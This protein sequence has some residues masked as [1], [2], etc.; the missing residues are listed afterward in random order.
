MKKIL[1]CDDEDLTRQGIRRILEKN[2]PEMQ[3]EECGNGL[4][5][6]KKLSMGGWDMLISDIKM[7][8]MSGLELIE[9]AQNGGFL[10]PTV[11]ISAYGEF[12]YAR[13][14]VRFGVKEYL[15]KPINRFELVDCVKRIL[16]EE[17][18][19]SASEP[20]AGERT[21]LGTVDKAIEYI[22]KNFFKNISLEEVSKVVF[23]NPNYFSVLFKKE[24]GMKYI[25]YL[26]KLRLEKADNLLSSTMLQVNEV[27]T[28][29]GY[30][31]TKYF[32]RLYKDRYGIL[33]SER[34]G[35]TPGEKTKNKS[36]I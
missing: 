16:G 18:I 21:E 36:Q 29:V 4:D 7:P 25:D 10:V 27:A 1:I 20:P 9:R 3:L 6:Y 35:S 19:K 13:T 17:S 12:E 8:V 2:F 26:T 14:A 34:R 30:S 5:A 32:T 31:S 33:P 24:T 28:M 15:L 23:M 22:E 11:I